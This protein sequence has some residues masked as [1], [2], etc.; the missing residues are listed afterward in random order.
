MLP[1]KILTKCAFDVS[2]LLAP[3]YVFA[4]STDLDCPSD[5][6]WHAEFACPAK[7]LVSNGSFLGDTLENGYIR[8]L[9]YVSGLA[10]Q[11]LRSD[12]IHS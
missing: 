7:F 1:R 11:G 10:V 2:E 8:W 3:K 6:E 12:H 4:C 5:I 9:A